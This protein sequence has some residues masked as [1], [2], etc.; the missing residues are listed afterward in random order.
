MMNM[1]VEIENFSAHMPGKGIETTVASRAKGINSVRS[2]DLE[3]L[4]PY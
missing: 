1:I 2:D 4:E 3:D